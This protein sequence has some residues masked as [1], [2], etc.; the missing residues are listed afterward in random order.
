MRPLLL[1]NDFFLTFRGEERLRITP[2]PGHTAE[3]MQKLV[4]AL[5]CIWHERKL[6]TV[7]DWALVGGRANVGVKNSEK[8]QLVSME[9][10]LPTASY[11][12]P[13]HLEAVAAA[14]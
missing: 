11:V 13:V 2:T 9:D 6:R 3:H 7:D 12:S 10:I 1:S 5:E 4:D 14:A 8:E